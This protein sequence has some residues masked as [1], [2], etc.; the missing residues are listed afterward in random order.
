MCQMYYKMRVGRYRSVRM[1]QS[2]INKL[3]LEGDF[4]AEG[5]LDEMSYLSGCMAFAKEVHEFGDSRLGGEVMA[6]GK[7][8]VGQGKTGT[9][10]GRYATIAALSDVDYNLA[11]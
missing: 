6:G 1:R 10:Y 7:T 4:T 8:A 3:I 11:V 5:C 9:V 2:H